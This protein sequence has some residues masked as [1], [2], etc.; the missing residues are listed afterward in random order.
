MGHKKIICPRSLG[1][2]APGAPPESASVTHTVYKCILFINACLDL[3]N[4]TEYGLNYLS[5]FIL[6]F[7]DDI[8]LFTTDITSLQNQLDAVASYSNKWGLKINVNKNK[9]CT[10]IVF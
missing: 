2:H 1:S 8:A 10:C 9:K 5:M 6:L 3:Q 4:L 7:A